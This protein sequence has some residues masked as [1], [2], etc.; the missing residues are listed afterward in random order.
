MQ[1]RPVDVAGPTVRIVVLRGG[2]SH[3]RRPGV[4]PT[5]ERGVMAL[6]SN[7]G[8]WVLFNVSAAVAQQ[9]GAD[10]G[11]DR[12]SGLPDAP[13]RAVVLTDAQ[14]DHIGGLLGLR[15]GAPIDLYA[16]PAV[17]EDLTTTLPVLPVLEHY[18]GV[19]WHVV[20]V[21]GDQRIAS[22]RV[23]GMANLEFTAVSIDA[24]LPPYSAHGDRGIVGS[25]IALAVRD[26]DTDQ[27][28]FCAPGLTQ[29]G[30]FEFE[31]MRGADCLLVD[32]PGETEESGL[33]WLD[34]LG[35]LPARHK[36][37][38]GQSQAVHQAGRDDL[39]RRGIE[40]AFDGMEI[41]L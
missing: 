21:A 18:C 34:L 41:R 1:R 12:H 24:P 7:D 20:P 5:R 2:A 26:L 23:D 22:F 35:E 30:A 15:D 6:E 10:A 14:V 16:T 37:L 9:L 17:F 8:Q 38:F 27:R 19:H 29:V 40:L 11:L 4:A 31:W 3:R 39:A 32:T 13:I 25:T 36:V 33:P 28:I